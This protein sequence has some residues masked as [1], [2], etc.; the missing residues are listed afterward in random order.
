MFLYVGAAYG[1]IKE[2]GGQLRSTDLYRGAAVRKSVIRFEEKMSWWKGDF[3][4][5]DLIA[6]AINKAYRDLMR[7]ISGFARNES[8][9]AIL[10]RAKKTLHESITA[11]LSAEIHTQGE[12]NKL[13]EDACSDLV[14]AFRGQDF[15]V[16]QAQ[17]WINMTFKYLHLLED[18]DVQRVYEFCHVPIDRY[19]LDITNYKG[20]GAWSRLTDYGVY[21]E[22]Q[23]WFRK[24][25]PDDIPLDKEFYLW[26]EAARKQKE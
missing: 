2:T 12:F 5:D 22:Y 1:K 15:T 13:H 17:K 18:P 7:T 20:I 11:I 10:D 25:Y 16:G 21:Q 6:L 14:S 26:L 23:D 9:D 24:K 3:Y 4:A 19:M 8:H